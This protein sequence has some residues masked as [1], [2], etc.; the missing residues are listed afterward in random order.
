M[1]NT[2]KKEEDQLKPTTTGTG[3][4]SYTGYVTP[5][6]PDANGITNIPHIGTNGVY[7]NGTTP[8]SNGKALINVPT[9]DKQY[10]IVGQHENGSTDIREKDGSLDPLTPVYGSKKVEDYKPTNFAQAADQDA[11]LAKLTGLEEQGRP[12]YTGSYDQQIQQLL[13]DIYERG[14]FTYNYNEDPLYQQYAESYTQGGRNAMRDTMGQAAALTGGYG[15]TYASMAGQQ[16]YNNYMQGLADKIPEL[17]QIAANRYDIE[18]QNMRDN[19]SMYN[20]QD[21]LDY[22]KY[23]YDVGDYESDRDYAY[24]KWLAAQQQN[25]YLTELYQQY[26]KL[27]PNYKEKTVRTLLGYK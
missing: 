19:L 20:N 16:Q 5:V 14:P 12:V 11:A 24:N 4:N 13:G 9:A 2:Y 21:G 23:R 22:T 25:N 18:T 1:S 8:F 17:Y 6:N 26:H 10:D 7:A 3:G 15:N 27:D